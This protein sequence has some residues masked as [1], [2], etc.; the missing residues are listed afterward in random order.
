[1]AEGIA[2]DLVRDAGGNE[3]V[4][5]GEHLKW[6][7]TNMGLAARLILQLRHSLRVILQPQDRPSHQSHQPPRVSE[8]GS[9]RWVWVPDRPD[10][11]DSELSSHGAGR[12][13]T[14]DSD[15][16][17][18]SWAGRNKRTAQAP[19]AERGDRPAPAELA[20]RESRPVPANHAAIPKSSTYS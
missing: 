6:L 11:R 17:A 1:M 3:V 12:E 4:I 9:W 15:P 8:P 13:R 14:G 2:Q 18:A 19:R 16:I 7:G 20:E 5:L 10:V